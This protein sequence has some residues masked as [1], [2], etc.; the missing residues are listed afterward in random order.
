[1]VE[2]VIDQMFEI[3]LPKLSK[4]IRQ[5]IN[6]ASD[7]TT[8]SKS[9]INQLI[10]NEDVQNET[11]YKCL[12]DGTYLLSMTLNFPN[13]TVDMIEWWFWWYSQSSTYYRLWYP[14]YHSS[15]I[16]LDDKL[17][18]G[19]FHGFEP[20]THHVTEDFGKGNVTLAIK[21]Q[22]PWIFGF[23]K[24]LFKDNNIGTVFCATIGTI[25]GVIGHS[26]MVHVIKEK[27]EGIQIISRF[28]IGDNIPR[29]IKRRLLNEDTAYLI[30][31]HYFI[32]YTRLNEILPPLY[33]TYREKFYKIDIGE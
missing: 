7:I 5:K 17:Y 30:S 4:E 3:P 9:N 33:D 28:W 19:K 23:D 27:D 32:E 25:G 13:L 2:N 14:V 16:N 1:M 31:K 6:K 15:I 10:L 26:K 22:N 11:G 21:F 29:L 12:D 8:I 20:C 18:K 24:T